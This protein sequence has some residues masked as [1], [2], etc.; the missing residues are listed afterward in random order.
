MR[1]IFLDTVGLIAMWNRSDQWHQAATAAFT[2]LDPS[3]TRTVTTSCILL[4]CG[5]EAAR[6]PYRSEVLALRQALQQSG[7]LYDPTADEV[8]QAWTAYER[9]EA[10]QAGI[11]DHVSFVLMRRLGITEAFSND[12]HFQAAGFTTLF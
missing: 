2:A 8:E 9:G 10:G 12:R 7:C 4:E 1:T 5:N 11:V 6:R 3:L